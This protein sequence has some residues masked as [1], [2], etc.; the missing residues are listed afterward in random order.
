MKEKI[1][2]AIIELFDGAPATD[3]VHELQEEM[4]SNAEEK[5]EDLTQRGF[6]P[7]QAYTMVMASIGDVQELLADIA[8]QEAEQDPD[9]EAAGKRSEYWEKN[10][11]YWK[12]QGEYWE[13]QAR[14]L[15]QQAKGALNSIRE[16][17][18]W[19]NITSSVKQII[20]GVGANMPGED[21]ECT[22]MELRNERSFATSGIARIMAELQNSPVDL[23]VALTTDAEIRVEELYNKEPRQGQLLEFSINGDTLKLSYGSGAIGI[24]RRGVVRISLPEEFAG[25]LEEF[26]AV[27]ASGDVTIQELGAAKQVIKTMSGD[28][29][30][31]YALGNITLSTASGDV[32]Y[33]TIQ[34]ECQVKTASG[35]IVIGQMIGKIQQ[36]SASGDISLAQLEG[37]GS[38]RTA[39]GDIDVCVTKAG[40]KLELSAASGDVKVMLPEDTSLRMT[41]S[42]ASGDIHTFFDKLYHTE[43]M[44]DYVKHGRN[45]VGT[46]GAEPYLQLKISTASGDVSVKR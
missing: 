26:Y 31:G 42:T 10:S 35:D 32:E 13:K 36:N 12:W 38:F 4:I 37:D 40:E 20:G 28:I 18:I 34:G 45:A 16:S 30:G 15:G 21:G 14:S 43:E 11:E 3:E 46:I 22:D 5:Y 23:E 25:S 2:E 1:R 44:V 8:A 41:V 9:E 7:D 33:A 39:S 24:P 17:G 29:K 27:T 6:L 19:E